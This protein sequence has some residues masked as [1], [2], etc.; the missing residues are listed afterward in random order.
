MCHGKSFKV[1]TTLDAIGLDP[2]SFH[3]LFLETTTNEEDRE[4]LLKERLDSIALSSENC[5]S[6][7]TTIAG[8]QSSRAL[9]RTFDFYDSSHRCFKE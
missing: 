8:V 7:E 5:I 1:E 9:G 4:N 2:T 3:F 6:I